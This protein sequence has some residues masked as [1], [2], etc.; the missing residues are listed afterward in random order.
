MLRVV[1][2]A[3]GTRGGTHSV[4]RRLFAA[5]VIARSKTTKQSPYFPAFGKQLRLLRFARNDNLN[6]ARLINP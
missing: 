1:T 6:P 4:V 5:P 3:N 2:Q